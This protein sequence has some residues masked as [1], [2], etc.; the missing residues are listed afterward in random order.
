ISVDVGFGRRWLAAVVMGAFAWFSLTTSYGIWYHFPHTFV[1]D[2]FLCPLFE[3][4]VAGVAIAAI[5]RRRIVVAAATV[6]QCK[7]VKAKQDN[8]FIDSS[9]RCV[10]RFAF[11]NRPGSCRRVAQAAVPGRQRSSSARGAL[12]AASAGVQTTR[13]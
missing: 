8:A 2:E 10:R 3:W 4:S 1:H 6:E 5:V 7:C 9:R 13:H 12:R 11:V